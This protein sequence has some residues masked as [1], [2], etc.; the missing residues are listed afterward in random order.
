MDSESTANN[1]FVHAGKISKIGR[2]S[3]IVSLKDNVHCESCRAKGTCGVADSGSKEIEIQRSETSFQLHENVNVVL[4]KELGLKA[5]FWAYVFPFMLMLL[6]LLITS[7]F[8]K[9]WIAGL[10]SLSILLPYYAILYVLK[11]VLK[12]SFKIS[13]LKI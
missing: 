4:K 10:L 9:E 1:T 12:E 6:T 8:L 2:N 11:D 7:G 3:I 5:V 13:I